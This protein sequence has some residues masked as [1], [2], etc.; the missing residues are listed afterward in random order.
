[1]NGVN[2]NTPIMT[3]DFIGSAW[4]SAPEFTPYAEAIRSSYPV[5]VP[6]YWSQSLTLARGSNQPPPKITRRTQPYTYDILVLGAAIVTPTIQGLNETLIDYIYLNISHRST[7][8]R[9]TTANQIAYAP[10]GSIAGTDGFFDGFPVGRPM[11]ILRLPEA[12]FLPANT[13]LQFDWTLMAPP[14]Q[15]PT[16]DIIFTLIGLRFSGGKR[17]DKVAMPDGSVI[18][19][20]SRIPW[21]STIA[22]GDYRS[23][24]QSDFQLEAGAEVSRF[25]P[26]QECD[27]EIQG[28]H[29]NLQPNNATLITMKLTDM[30]EQKFWTP[31]RAPSVSFC[32]YRTMAHPVLPFCKPYLLKSGHRMRIVSLNNVAANIAQ[33]S[34]VT[35][36]GV[37]RCEY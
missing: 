24:N 4:D 2:N 23:N 28:A 10:V 11:P 36:R 37:Q 15:A 27:V 6:W 32:G 20:G 12:F 18:P 17:P 8:V 5:Q 25:F 13:Q 7:G 21:F 29:I 30:G 34:V 1:M 3:G 16:I 9:W 14:L 35:L 31:S 33:S 26:P 19:V 22:I